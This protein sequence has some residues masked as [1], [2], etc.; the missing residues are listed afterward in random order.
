MSMS[1]RTR[2]FCVSGPGCATG[3]TRI[4]TSSTATWPTWK[5]RRENGS[6]PGSRTVSC[7]PSAASLRRKTSAATSSMSTSGPISRQAWPHGRNGHALPGARGGG[8]KCLLRCS[9]YCCCWRSRAGVVASRQRR[10]A[11]NQAREA[12]QQAALATSRD[13]TSRSQSLVATQPDVALLLSVEAQRLH[14]FPES[15]AGLLTTDFTSPGLVRISQRF[16]G[17]G[18]SD[19]ALSPDGRTIA[20]AYASGAL[21]LWNFSSQQPTT[22]V[23]RF[24]KSAVSSLGDIDAQNLA[25]SW[26]D[27]TV[28]LID[29]AT[30]RAHGNPLPVPQALIDDFPEEIRS[31]PDL[32]VSPDGAIMAGFAGGSTLLRWDT[33]TGRLLGSAPAGERSGCLQRGQCADR[34]TGRRL[35]RPLA[36]L[37]GVAA[38]HQLQDRRA[39]WPC[40]RVREHGR[41][42]HGAQP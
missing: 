23:L 21:R 40:H 38:R 29:V 6:A 20:I 11:L 15:R 37:S 14:D 10:D 17:S 12:R 26:K 42:P 19:F 4:G 27:G 36:G 30:G 24:D 31:G 22:P 34:R 3:S 41:R 13:L 2:H 1:L 7:T 5:P 33:H 35:E 39:S 8:C 32:S 16:F 28:R 9:S 18:I 25:V